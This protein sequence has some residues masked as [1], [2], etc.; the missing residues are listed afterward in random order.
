MKGGWV[1]LPKDVRLTAPLRRED[2]A[3]LVVGDVVHLR[4]IRSWRSRGP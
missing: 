3:D 1:D 2:V 4:W